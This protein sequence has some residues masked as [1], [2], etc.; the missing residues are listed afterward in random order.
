M[1]GNCFG[2][3]PEGKICLTCPDGTVPDYPLITFKEL[4]DA[5]NCKFAF[6]TSYCVDISW[7]LSYFKCPLHLLV[8]PN[9]KQTNAQS[10]QYNKNVKISFPTFPSGFG[11]F[12]AKIMLLEYQKG[13]RIVITSANLVDHDY[14]QVQNILFVQDLEETSAP[15]NSKFL[16]DLKTFLK[17]CSISPE[18]ITFLERF[19]WE[20][21][22][23][24]L[25][26]AFLAIIIP[27]F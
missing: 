5:V 3:F 27:V 12:H 14:G 10:I 23:E 25:F 22:R 6:L 16:A 7:I 8:H 21:S 13:L 11:V 9:E 4:I 15:T 1:S 2:S 17:T 19:N 24:I 18:S 20:R 26:L